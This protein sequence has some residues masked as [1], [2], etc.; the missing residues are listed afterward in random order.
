MT[1]E[2]VS[3]ARYIEIIIFLVKSKRAIPHLAI[4]TF[5]FLICI[6]SKY[7]FDQG[8]RI[9]FLEFFKFWFDRFFWR[10]VLLTYFSVLSS[11]ASFSS[12]AKNP[13][14]LIWEYIRKV[15]HPAKNCKKACFVSWSFSFHFEDLSWFVLLFSIWSYF[16]PFFL[17]FPL[18][19]KVPS[20]RSHTL[21]IISYLIW[22][23]LIKVKTDEKFENWF[24][25]FKFVLILIF[26][27]ELISSLL[28]YATQR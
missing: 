20:K 2:R 23:L 15:R 25:I 11:R 16:G 4:S 12:I 3:L 6:L 14:K 22:S 24:L 17:Y 1:F 18:I 13:S 19:V 26:N 7:R 10:R 5:Y 28:S 9:L 8:R 21:I 27:W